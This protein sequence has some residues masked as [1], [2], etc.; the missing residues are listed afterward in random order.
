MDFMA[1]EKTSA[2]A[3]YFEF[4]IF[5]DIE[6]CIV[7]VKGKLEFVDLLLSRAVLKHTRNCME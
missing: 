4:D 7:M 2:A 6:V 5:A 3:W 1:F